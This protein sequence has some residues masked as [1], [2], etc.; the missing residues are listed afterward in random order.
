MDFKNWHFT[1]DRDLENGLYTGG[2]YL[3]NWHFPGGRD[4]EN[5]HFTGDRDFKNWQKTVLVR[6]SPLPL[7]VAALFTRCKKRV[8]RQEDLLPGGTRNVVTGCYDC[9][10]YL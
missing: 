6:A 7:L 1:G 9:A 10:A 2:I 5:C 3:E 4:L 8:F